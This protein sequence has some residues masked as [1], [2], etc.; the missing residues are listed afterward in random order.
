MAL[1]VHNEQKQLLSQWL[2]EKK[3]NAMQLV[4]TTI[5]INQLY[6]QNIGYCLEEPHLCPC[7]Q[8]MLFIGIMGIPLYCET[9]GIDYYVIEIIESHVLAEK[10]VYDGWNSYNVL[11]HIQTRYFLLKQ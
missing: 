2:Q 9:D 8:G 11:G 4:L 7:S 6:E 1:Q 10:T 5:L 3:I